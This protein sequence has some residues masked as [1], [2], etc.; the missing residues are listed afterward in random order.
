MFNFEK[1]I[2]KK[3]VVHCK[4]YEESNM[5]CKEMREAGIKMKHDIPYSAFW[6]FDGKN[7]CYDF[8]KG[9]HGSINVYKE[10][11]YKILEYS[12]YMNKKENEKIKLKNKMIFTLNGNPGSG[13]DEFSKILNEFIPTKHISIVDPI[14]IIE[15]NIRINI[16]KEK[17]FKKDEK[18]RKFLSDLK[19]VC[20]EYNDYSFQWV[21]NE[22]IIFLSKSDN[23]ILL[24]DMR[25]EKD[26]VRAEYMFN[27][28]SI[29]I[30]NNRAK[31]IISNHADANV[32]K[33]NYNYII[34]NNGTLEE[35]KNEVENFVNKINNC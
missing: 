33:I 5:F 19:D 30:E 9:E 26:I 17:Y 25:S 12:N 23:D 29:F 11:G 21:I 27:A 10:E 18:Y 20:E 7:T 14:K 8:N 16:G 15:E 22:V 3:V 4:T 24:I 34:K 13:K 1:W 6:C 28:E 35:F 2:N 31:R 32:E